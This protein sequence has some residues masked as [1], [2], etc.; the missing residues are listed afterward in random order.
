MPVWL[1]HHSCHLPGAAQVMALSA[2]KTH[3]VNTIKNKPVFI[4]GEQ[5][6]ELVASLFLN[7]DIEDYLSTRRSMAFNLLA[8]AAVDQSFL[9]DP[10]GNA[11]GPG[12]RY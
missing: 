4:T 5:A 1:A 9:I 6:Y 10:L 2:D 12:S 3:S 7:S 11:R 8:S